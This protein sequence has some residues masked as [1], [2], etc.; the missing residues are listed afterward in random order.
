[1]KSTLNILL[2]FVTLLTFFIVPF[3]PKVLVS[4]YKSYLY[5]DEYFKTKVKIDSVT[6]EN[7][8][9]SKGSRIRYYLIYYGEKKMKLKYPNNL[10]TSSKIDKKRYEYFS[11]SKKDSMY[12]WLNPKAEPIFAMRNEETLVNQ[13]LKNTFIINVL[14]A[15]VSLLL[16]IRLFVILVKRKKD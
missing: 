4:S 11:Q 1:M 14:F 15:C 9:G 10:I 12:I 6:F 13:D 5:K 3:L 8:S 16:Y 7:E 2:F